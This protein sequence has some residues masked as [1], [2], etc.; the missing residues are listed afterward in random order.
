[1]PLTYRVYVFSGVS[2]HAKRSY[3]EQVI[4]IA[5]SSNEWSDRWWGYIPTWPP[6]W[7]LMLTIVIVNYIAIDPTIDQQRLWSRCEG[8]VYV[9][10]VCLSTVIMPHSWGMACMQE[11]NLFTLHPSPKDLFSS[12]Q[13][14]SP[15][16]KYLW[17]WEPCCFLDEFFSQ[18]L[19]AAIWLQNR[20]NQ[21][22]PVSSLKF[23]AGLLQLMIHTIDPLGTGKFNPVTSATANIHQP[24][25]RCRW[26]CPYSIPSAL[27]YWACLSANT[28]SHKH[29]EF[30][31]ELSAH[32]KHFHHVL[33]WYSGIMDLRNAR[34]LEALT[35][36]VHNLP[37]ITLSLFMACVRIKCSKMALAETAALWPPSPYRLVGISSWESR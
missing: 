13:L 29:K 5:L 21:T 4:G 15:L 32:V 7:L 12:A 24:W 31:S 1:M 33:A 37:R 30:Y 20:Q 25:T 11:F 9:D 23:R 2:T 10:P 35:S 6:L 18:L 22:K 14:C 17:L 16:Y 28:G 8:R 27:G 34:W 36:S 3:L 19:I 26:P